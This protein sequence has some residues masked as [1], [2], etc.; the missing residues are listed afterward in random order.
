MRKS[1]IITTAFALV[2]IPAALCAQQGG[3]RIPA[4]LT[5][6]EA[7]GIAR[8]N[9]PAYRKTLNDIG[10]AAAGVRAGWGR[11]LPSASSSMSWGGSQ[12]TNYTT[13]DVFGQPLSE[14]QGI[15]TRGSNVSQ[16]VSLG[17]TLFDGGRMFR[18]Y[19]RARASER[20]T[21][22]VVRAQMV[23][24]EANVTRQYYAAKRSDLLASV[25]QRNLA[26]ARDRL[27]RTEQLFRLAGSTQVDLLGA[28]R[29]VVQA[30]QRLAD[31]ESE[32]HKA[33]LQL[34]E[35]LG[36]SGSFEFQLTGDLPAAFDPATLNA[37]AIVA[38]AVGSSPAVLQSQ[39]AAE[40]A[41]QSAASARGSR[42]PTVN[43][44]VGYGRSG[45]ERG[46]GAIGDIN[47]RNRSFSFGV[48]FSYPIF[49]RFGTSQQIAQAEASADDAAQD[50]R[51][52]RLQ[53]ERETRA[54]LVD[55]EKAFRGLRTAEEVAGI[56][57]QRLE[58]A[59]EL[60]RTGAASMNF[61][62]LQLM[63][64]DNA[65]AQRQVV[66]ARVAFVNA[67]VQLEQILGAPLGR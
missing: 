24:V 1:T 67:R 29:D 52:A 11:F 41:R 31:A 46:Y 16:N 22:A 53:A 15:T 32:A 14:P 62:Q 51:Q 6:E 44:S 56:V 45:S 65:N 18:D 4:T 38:Q 48:S 36:V 59:E 64:E 35:T 2:L 39:A 55:L 37:D 57:A 9:N 47:P 21:E 28:R 50:L 8:E 58:L 33:R 49:Q 23:T 63:V 34:Q 27:D 30:E 26:S 7:L 3:A 19:A 66:E 20:Q 43:G 12:S 40:Q 13:T 10:V 61:Q 42:W 5:L 25:E 54:A 60:F 17:F